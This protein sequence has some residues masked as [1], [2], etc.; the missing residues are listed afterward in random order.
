MNIYDIVPA[1]LTGKALFEHVVK[2]E[3]FILHAKRN[4]IKSADGLHPGVMFVDDNGRLKTKA[5]TDPNFE[6]IPDDSEELMVKAA[7]NTTN[8]FDSCWDVHINGIW[9]KSLKDN[10]TGFYLLKEHRQYFED[11][12]G[13]GLKA[14]VVKMS[15]A[16]LGF[17]QYEGITEVLL[18]TGKIMKERNPYMFDQYRKRRVKQHSVGMRYVKILTCINDDDYPVQKENWDKYF[19]MIVNKEDA[20]RAGIFWA[21]LEAKC[22]EGSAVLFGANC[23]TPTVGISASTTNKSTDEEPSVDTPEQPQPFDIM[24]AIEKTTFLKP[25][26]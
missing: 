16:D 17:P 1:G 20:E 12:I 15:W 18:F 14:K 9:G 11:V 13:E 6:E 8:Y 5:L 22:I 25:I 24:K 4:E 7:I 3:A 21:V 2:N 10:T 23:L 19:P 26:N